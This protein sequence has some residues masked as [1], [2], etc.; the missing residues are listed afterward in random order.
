M[1][2]RPRVCVI[3]EGSYPYITGGVSS[4]MHELISQIP[5]VD[6]VVYSISPKSDQEMRY[7][8]PENVVEHR[9]IVLSNAQRSTRRSPDKRRLFENLREFHTRLEAGSLADFD[10]IAALMPPGYF[11]YRDSYTT[12]IGWEMVTRG[13]QVGNPIYPFSDYFWAWKSAHDMLFTVIGAKAPKADLYHAISTGY[14]GLAA[15]VAKLRT[16]KPFLLT[17]HG[18]YHKERE[19]EIRRVRYIRGYQRDMWIKTYN[20]LSRLAYQHAD[21]TIALF[22]YNRRMQIELGASEEHTRVIANGIDI[23]R[24]SS[25]KRTEREGFHVG[26]V[27]RVVPIKD[28]K[29]F[30][31]M[32]RIIHDRYPDAQFYCIGPTDEDPAYF[33]DCK[34]MVK[35]FRLEDCFHFTGRADVR[36]YY[37]FID[38]LLLTSVREAQPL[39]I[40]EAYAAGIPV[41]ATNVGNVPEL[42]D[43]DDRF[44]SPSKDPQKLA[45]AVVYIREHPEE[46]REVVE[47]NRRKTTSFYDRKSVFKSYLE[48]YRSLGG[49]S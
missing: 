27:G 31:S 49:E 39:V 21:L 10:K 42:L 23:E 26:L 8:L 13:N 43:Y 5:E 4:W 32:S 46:M 7:R 20:G 24:F 2:D 22:E 34:T 9:D 37:S 12:D 48:I 45:E 17:E 18:L 19:M 33:Q 3:L 1:A 38:V 44:L 36:E 30:I 28:I 29:T 35:S 11:A 16:G 41:A 15:V 47:Q 25:I 40:L 14:A 6:F